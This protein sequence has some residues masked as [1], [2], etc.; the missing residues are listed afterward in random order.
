MDPTLEL[1]QFATLTGGAALIMGLV[2]VIKRTLDW[3]AKT[4]DRF[5]PIASILTGMVLM[6][7]LSVG[8]GND[9]AGG[10][11]EA[12]FAGLVTGLYACGLYS[13][14]GKP[15]INAVAGPPNS[16]NGVH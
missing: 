10:L 13:I 1:G 15:A 7:L 8:V 12:L 5:A 16:K 14:G 4:T 6:I 11:I 9:L 3:D 2:E